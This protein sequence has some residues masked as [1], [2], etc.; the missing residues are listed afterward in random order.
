[1][2]TKSMTAPINHGILVMEKIRELSAYD[3]HPPG[4]SVTSIY[5]KTFVIINEDGRKV[6]WYFDGC[7]HTYIICVKYF[8]WIYYSR[9]AALKLLNQYFECRANL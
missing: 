4:V 6:C 1:M 2:E 9:K 3:G 5:G 7:L 8:L